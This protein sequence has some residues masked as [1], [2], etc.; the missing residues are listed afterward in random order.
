[1]R[2]FYY[3]PGWARVWKTLPGRE[4]GPVMGDRVDEIDLIAM[5]LSVRGRLNGLVETFVIGHPP[6]RLV[7]PQ[8]FGMD[9]PFNR[10]RAPRQGV[11]EMRTEH[12]RTFGFF[13]RKDIFV[14]LALDLTE[15][16][17]EQP[18]RYESYGDAVLRVLARMAATEKD[19]SSPLDVLVGA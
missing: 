17:H 15:R 19:E 2:S 8:G 18:D 5:D 7:R 1:M 14:A 12:T 11:V 9:P 6:A 13:V 3:S 4:A 10:M 16:T